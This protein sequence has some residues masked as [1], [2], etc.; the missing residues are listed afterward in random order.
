MNK[1]DKI[2]VT[3]KAQGNLKAITRINT[4]AF[5]ITRGMRAATIAILPIIISLILNQPALSTATLGTTFIAYTEAQ[6]SSITR[7]YLLTACLTQAAA[8]GL[9]ILASAT[10]PILSPVLLAVAVT[11]ILTARGNPKWQSIAMYSAITFAVG[12]GITGYSGDIVLGTG[13]MALMAIAGGL[14]GILGIELQRLFVQKRKTEKIATL[15]FQQALSYI[16]ALKNAALVGVAS[17]IGYSIGLALGLPRDFWIVITIIAVIRPNLNSTIAITSMR[18]IGTLAGGLVAVAVVIEIN[19]PFLQLILLFCFAA[20]MF[21]C[22]GVNYAIAQ[23]FLVPYVILLLNFAYPGAWYF[24]FYRVLDVALGCVIGL[25]AVFL[26]NVFTKPNVVPKNV[27]IK[28]K[29]TH[30]LRKF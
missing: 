13:F 16:D 21:A 8:F 29:T 27:L 10:G 20:M 6:S 28:E 24:V 1:R 4:D 22:R 11:V 30:A 23:V 14:L 25:S 5:S 3:K 7:K 18:L 17:A 19:M 15:R 2:I 26:V 12:L 9:G